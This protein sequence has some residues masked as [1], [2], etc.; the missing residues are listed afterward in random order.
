MSKRK[1]ETYTRVIEI[2]HFELDFL[3]L[4]NLQW[5]GKKKKRKKNTLNAVLCVSSQVYLLK[6]PAT[7]NT[8]QT[9]V[10]SWRNCWDTLIPLLILF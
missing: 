8:D 5:D 3:N 4:L 6:E 1:A 7:M 10:H 9:I 2:S